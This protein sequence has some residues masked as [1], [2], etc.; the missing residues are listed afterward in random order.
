VSVSVT[1]QRIVDASPEAVFVVL[2]DPW[3]YARWVGWTREIRAAEP[4]WPRPGTRLWH[5]F[6][7]WPVGGRGVTVVVSCERPH[8]LVLRADVRPLALVRATL[9][10]QRDG[11]GTMVQIREDMIG[12]WARWFGPA[13]TLVQR[14][15]N[16]VSLRDLAGVVADHAASASTTA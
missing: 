9:S 4:G 6:G 2:A 5:R 15:R 13:T 3:S 14:R 10:V 1:V 7:R 11:A 8:R 12:G 16:E